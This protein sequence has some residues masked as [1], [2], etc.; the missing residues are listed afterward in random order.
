MQRAPSSSK[1][2]RTLIIVLAA[3]LVVGNG[4]G[5]LLS[6]GEIDR[7]GRIH[8]LGY[9]IVSAVSLSADRDAVAS[10]DNSIRIVEHA[11]DGP[12]L[13]VERA[14]EAGITALASDSLSAR[15]MVGLTDGR[16]VVLDD[17]LVSVGG[18]Q[19]NGRVTGVSFGADDNAVVT[20]GRG[21][22]SEEYFVGRYSLDGAVRYDE[23]VGYTTNTVGSLVG[24]RAVYGTDDSRIGVVSHDG[25]VA[26]EVLLPRPVVGL[27]T[28]N[29]RRRIVAVDNSGG[30]H[31]LSDAGEV[32]LQRTVSNFPI[33]AVQVTREHDLV[34]VGDEDGM[35]RVLNADGRLLLTERSFAAGDRVA[36]VLTVPNEET[37]RTYSRSGALAIGTDDAPVLLA[38]RRTLRTVQ[39]LASAG[40]ASAIIVL[41]ILVVPRLRTRAASVAGKIY[42]SRLAYMLLLPSFVALAVFSYYP[43]VSAGYYS[44]TNF[45]LARP[46]KF[47][48]FE[49]YIRLFQDFYFWTGMGNLAKVLVTQILKDIT[50]PL[51]VAELIFWLTNDKHKYR[52]RTAFVVPSIVPPV[53]MVLLWKMIYDPNVGLINQVLE[54]IGL[55]EYTMAW[56]GNEATALG[57]VIFAGFPWVSVFAF[58]VYSGGLININ[59]DIY[60]AA[61]I[62]GIRTWRRFWSIDVPMLRPQ[63]RIIL[64]FSYVTSIQ[65]FANIW[66]FTRG[67]P[68]SATYVPGLH[69]F[70]KISDGEYGYASAIGVVL[71]AIAFAGTMLN[72]RFGKTV[73][74]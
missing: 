43:I 64:F 32:L 21:Q 40:L 63:F 60:D 6:S 59:Q 15:L 25:G 33:T 35:L 20:Y 68:G 39:M 61:K 13:A 53:V 36:A 56:L 29:D 42:K 23:K 22:Y 47:I 52:F 62:D 4:V 18:F 30:V 73:E 57:A 3:V 31:V 27:S 41:T 49:N 16:V 70:F 2:L 67:G 72:F 34:F 1:I 48:G 12:E 58:L 54:Q 65:A 38:R 7:F 11:I 74:D 46:L 26:W 14:F 66:I 44:L 19:V 10:T 5:F 55:S 17:R 50:I 9:S 71:F 28:S 24:G 8:E 51:L 69:M 37:V 45:S